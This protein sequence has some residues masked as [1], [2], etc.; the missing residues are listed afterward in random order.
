MLWH[1]VAD[2]GFPVGGCRP[3]RGGVD[4]RGSYVLKILYVEKKESGTR[5]LDPPMHCVMVWDP[6]S[7]NA[8]SNSAIL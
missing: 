4:S 3:R 2:P 8:R 6:H 5:P 7:S 1:T